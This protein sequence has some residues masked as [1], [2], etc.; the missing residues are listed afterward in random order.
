[1]Q[2]LADFKPELNVYVIP[3]FK[4]KVLILKRK[5]N[6]WE[7]PG[8]GVEFGEH[9]ETSAK[10]ET[11]EETGLKVKELK[12]LGIT[13]AVYDKEGKKKHSVYIIYLSHVDSDEFKLSSEHIEGRWVTVDELRFLKLGL[14]AEEA[15]T[16]ISTQK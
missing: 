7:F 2:T 6:L 9:P 5:N 11:F 3:F 13:S 10:R 16:L 12:L 4:D 1:M 8:G 15:L 14:N